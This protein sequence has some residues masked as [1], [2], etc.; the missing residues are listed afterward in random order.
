M[1]IRNDDFL[2]AE[3]IMREE[4]EEQRLDDAFA[5]GRAYRTK[6]M[7]ECREMIEGQDIDFQD[8]FWQGFYD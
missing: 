5:S 2:L 7:R 3:Q 6:I 8:A 4:E 1:T